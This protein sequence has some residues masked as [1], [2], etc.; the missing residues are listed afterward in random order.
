MRKCTNNTE[1]GD[2]KND[3]EK[4]HLESTSYIRETTEDWKSVSFINALNIK[5][6]N[7]NAINA[8]KQGKTFTKE[9][10]INLLLVTGSPRSLMSS[11]T[12]N[13]LIINKFGNKTT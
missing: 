13:I 10:E 11:N 7:T 12:A 6:K 2:E 8:N 9:K 1:Y 5:S 4:I 3:D